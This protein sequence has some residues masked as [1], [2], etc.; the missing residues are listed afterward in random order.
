MK[1]EH[2]PLIPSIVADT[3]C[4][5]VYTGREASNLSASHV[6]RTEALR[7]RMTDDDINDFVIQSDKR[8]RAA[9]SVRARWFMSC[10]NG[11]RGRNQLYVW[12][13]H[14]LAAYLKGRNDCIE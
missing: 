8:C 2:L 9:Y 4:R 14:H 6:E 5:T 1:Y 3:V 11:N 13:S 10:L 7:R 12:M